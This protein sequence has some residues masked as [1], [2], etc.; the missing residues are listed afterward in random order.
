MGVSIS[1]LL[2]EKTSMDPYTDSTPNTANKWQQ[3]PGGPPN[4]YPNL[5]PRDSGLYFADADEF[6]VSEILAIVSSALNWLVATA[7]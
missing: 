7:L 1:Q 2:S 6:H 5:S 4:P 3:P